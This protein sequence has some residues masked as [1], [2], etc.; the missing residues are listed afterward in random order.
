MN[1]HFLP[2]A[3][4]ELAEA[5]AYYNRK[6]EGLGD[7]FAQEVQETIQRI[8]A[9]PRAWSVL[10]G[11]VRRCRTNRFPYG[12]VYVVEDEAVLIVAVMHQHR[13]PGYWQDRL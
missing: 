13:R 3:R 9:L 11:E 7:E 4:E 5:V 10:A 2:E 6:R 1:V 8:V 12:V